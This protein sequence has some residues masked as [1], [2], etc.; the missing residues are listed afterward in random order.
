MNGDFYFK[1]LINNIPRSISL[2][3]RNN[4]R[5]TYGC[6]DRD[7]WKYKIKPFPDITY[8][9]L[10]LPLTIVWNFP[11]K[12]N[13]YYKND[14]ILSIIK[15]GILF[16]VKNQ[17]RNGYFSEWYKGERSYV[18]TSFTVYAITESFQ[19]I[20][21]YFSDEE[22]KVIYKVFKNAGDWLLKNN[23]LLVANHTSGALPSLYNLHLILN[24]A[25]YKKGVKEKISTLFS[26]QDKEGWLLEYNGADAGYLNVSLCYIARYYFKSRD[27]SI[28]PQVKKIID[29]LVYMINP[30]GSFGGEFGSRSIKYFLPSGIELFSNYFDKAYYILKK[31]YNNIS[32]NILP[33]NVDDKYFSFF[34]LPDFSDAFVYSNKVKK[35]RGKNKIFKLPTAYTK[36]F[37]NAGIF[38]YK[39]DKYFFITNFKKGTPYKFFYSN[40]LIASENSICIK[41]GKNVYIS[42]YMD[43]NQPVQIKKNQIKIK[44]NFVKYKEIRWEL[45]KNIVFNL[46]L[47]LVS[48]SEFF[49]RLF[50]LYLKYTSVLKNK[51]V[52]I[53]LER[54]IEFKKDGINIKDIIK[55]YGFLIDVVWFDKG[56]VYKHIPSSEYFVSNDLDVAPHNKF[57]N[58]KKN[59]FI[60]NTNVRKFQFI[61][62][63]KMVRDEKKMEKSK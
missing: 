40:K 36:I 20:S 60:I 49:S 47:L 31:W 56:G 8:Q 16:W 6:F 52:N 53:C 28:L 3:D 38:I 48:K 15:S 17:N 2:C 25:R 18:A 11:Q 32:Y 41:K 37:K 39:N 35:K 14:N 7:Y 62:N 26:L 50:S 30:D 61:K 54:V 46:L 23:D 51:R 22:K 19:Y 34:L 42:E 21:N 57:L 4:L 63:I 12:D 45:L 9:Q 24:E 55:S 10:V 59:C 44:R 33:E 1:V 13:I 5:E 29:F 43:I 58:I 27:K